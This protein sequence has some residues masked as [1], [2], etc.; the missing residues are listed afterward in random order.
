MP[1]HSIKTER[2]VQVDYC[3]A[4]GPSKAPASFSSQT[5]ANIIEPFP[6]PKN[7]VITQDS[8]S[9]VSASR[10]STRTDTIV[11][12]APAAS[13]KM[14]VNQAKVKCVLSG[15][16]LVLTA[17]GN[18][19]SERILY[20]PYVTS[21][22]FRKEGEELWAYESR[23]ALRQLVVGKLIQFNILYTISS[24]KRE[25]G[26]VYLQDG[27]RLPEKMLE[28]GWLKLRDDAGKKEDSIEVQQHIEQLRAIEAKA[29][30]DNLGMF[31]NDVKQIDVK[32]DLG[33]PETFLQKWK[34]N[35]ID[36]LVERV[37]SGDRLLLRLL[38][39]PTEHAQVMILVAGIRAPNTDR[40]NSTTN[41]LQ[42]GEE[43]G[44]EA[45]N[46]VEERLLQRTVKVEI[47]GLSPQN[48]LIA[49]IIHPRG[50][51]AK[52]LLEAGLA[53]CADFHS[54]LLGAKMAPLREAEKK[55]MSA[56]RGLYKDHVPKNVGL[57]GNI[58][59]QVTRILSPDI[60]FVRD[61]A[62]VEK[63]ISFSS[64][65]G[66]RPTDPAESPFRDEAKEFLRKRIIGKNIRM[67]IDGSRPATDEYN[68]KDVATVTLN[69]KNI[70]LIMVQEGWG[71]VIRH[72]RDDTDRAPNYDE[73]LAAQEKAKEEKK[74][75][76]SGSPAKAKQF[77]DV[78]ETLQK[79][80]FQVG[81]LQ[82]QKKIPAV[83][84]YVK[85]G[86]RF[87]I[88]I[89]R[90]NIKLNLVLGGIRAPKSARN[91]TD[92]SEPFGQ[93]A[94][95]LAVKR[96]TQRDVEINV[97][98]LDKVGGF[99]GE[100]F[101]NK[102]SFG[103]ILVEEG[104]AAVH[105]YSAEQIGNSSELLAA[106]R[107]SQESRKGLWIDWDPSNDVD[108]EKTSRVNENEHQ[109]I[110]RE[111]DYRD[112]MITH[113]AENC[114][115]K[116]QIIGTGTAALETMMS[117]FR[118][119]HSNPANGKGLP[120]P[121]K[122][123]DYVAAKF[124][125]DGQWYRARIRSNDRTTKIAEVIYIDYGNSEKIA[126]SSL[127]PLSQEQF[128]PKKLR[129]QAQDAILSLLQ[130]PSNK[131]Y[132]LDAVQY[133]TEITEGKQLVA[134]IDYTAPDGIL[135][136]TLFDP[137][138]SEKLTDSINTE[139]VAAGHAMVPTK[140]KAWE[141]SFG[142]A[143]KTLQEKEEEAIQSRRGLWEYGDLRDD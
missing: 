34:G 93:E 130:F 106:Q 27:T 67:S 115:L 17:I 24:T 72:R 59:A 25:Y 101:I 138:Y 125:E 35:S 54:T 117:Q 69:N 97:H 131:D 3:G 124:S 63:R 61:R 142:D 36:G 68:S 140:L 53:R 81:A 74:G 55:A 79:A 113:I 20:L 90:E 120:G 15:D 132:L 121:P 45:K 118:T 77:V 52:F 91:P 119:F 83:V 41:Q 75:I 104:Y 11:T 50:S 30:S 2:N 143:L 89:P 47:V 129:P 6:A 5:F 58:E 44:N 86:S 70:G 133:L 102:E 29:R 51:I 98:S 134:N 8:I 39:S 135:Y 57:N 82:R 116:L 103:K 13:F 112:V 71:S 78:S 84:D 40:I 23:D 139:M 80:K 136:I 66:P 37:L 111:K 99:I 107:R 7:K 49:S 60:I 12:Q 108:D 110:Q 18:P 85:S 94:H 65:R 42:A 96:L 109:L 22:H 95:E 122:T 92:K 9:S 88:L 38:L 32:H 31:Q 105:E 26:E 28:L 141:R 48:L 43:Y 56:K 21:P 128:S 114:S 62:G 64:V 76:W 1:V 100:L 123:G 4:N 46:F 14:P 33:N 127:R 137:N 16:S 87:V 126:W 10:Q 19:K 73:L